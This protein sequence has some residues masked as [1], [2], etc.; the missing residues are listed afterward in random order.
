MRRGGGIFLN[1]VSLW[2]LF[3]LEKAITLVSTKEKKYSNNF[4]FVQFIFKKYI[5]TKS[6]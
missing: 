3:I 2:K 5:Y 1:I 4:N 6:F